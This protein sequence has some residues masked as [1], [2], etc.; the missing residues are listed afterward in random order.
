[1]AQAKTELMVENSGTIFPCAMES[2][3]AGAPLGRVMA[4]FSAFAVF[5]FYVFKSDFSHNP[6]L[7]IPTLH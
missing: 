7:P 6:K 3:E 5:M 1:M 4:H 2:R